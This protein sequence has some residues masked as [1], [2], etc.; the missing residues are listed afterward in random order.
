M[1]HYLRTKN[2]EFKI[3]IEVNC[4]HPKMRNNS[5]DSVNCNGN[6]CECKYAIATTVAA[7]MFELLE[8]ANCTYLQK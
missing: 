4:N 1:T 5:T 2:G 6:C 7:E 8:R 3:R